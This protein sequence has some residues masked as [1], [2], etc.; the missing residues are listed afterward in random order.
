MYPNYVLYL[1]GYSTPLH[2]AARGNHANIIKLLLRGSPSP[3]AGSV[4]VDAMGDRESLFF[5]DETYQKE[6]ISLTPLAVALMFGNVDAALALLQHG[7]QFNK[8]G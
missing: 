2:L 4:D 5:E 7:A 6:A 3:W 1:T 8:I